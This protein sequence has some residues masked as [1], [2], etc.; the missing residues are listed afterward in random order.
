MLVYEG[1]NESHPL[2]LV[3]IIQHD[4]I[5]C[6]DGISKGLPPSVELEYLSLQ[7]LVPLPLGICISW[8]SWASFFYT[9]G[10]CTAEPFPL[11]SRVAS[12]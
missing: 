9:V 10:S 5:M 7:A 8:I 11:L 4:V 3:A 12:R 2:L 6:E 1:S